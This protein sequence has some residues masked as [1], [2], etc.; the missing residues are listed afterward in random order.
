MEGGG[1]ELEFKFPGGIFTYIHLDYIRV[2]L[3]LR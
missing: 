3:Y 1:Q 2:E